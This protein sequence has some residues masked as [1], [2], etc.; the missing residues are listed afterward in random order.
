MEG[1]EA[2]EGEAPADDAADK[3]SEKSKKS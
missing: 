3:K 2:A 1:G